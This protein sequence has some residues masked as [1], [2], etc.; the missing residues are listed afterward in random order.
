MNIWQKGSGKEKSKYVEKDPPYGH[1]SPI[2]R[3]PELTLFHYTK[4]A[5]IWY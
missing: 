1:K 3:H 2:L 4:I 5:S